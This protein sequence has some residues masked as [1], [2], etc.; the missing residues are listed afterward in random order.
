MTRITLPPGGD[1]AKLAEVR[2]LARALMRIRGRTLEWWRNLFLRV[3]LKTC[4]HPVYSYKYSKKH[5]HPDGRGETYVQ[6]PM[7]CRVLRRYWISHP[8]WK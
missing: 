5:L 1:P 4:R 8:P 3:H 2:R 6:C 7:C